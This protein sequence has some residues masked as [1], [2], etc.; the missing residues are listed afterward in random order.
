MSL[1]V[2]EFLTYIKEV[3]DENTSI[4]LKAQ[5][6]SQLIN[7]L[8][9]KFMV[10]TK[11]CGDPKV[12]LNIIKS[13]VQSDL[14]N[15]RKVELRM[16]DV[17]NYLTQG[18]RKHVVLGTYTVKNFHKEENGTY[19]DRYFI[20]DCNTGVLNKELNEKLRDFLQDAINNYEPDEDDDISPCPKCGCETVISKD[21]NWICEKCGEVII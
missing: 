3:Y 13:I 19:T 7:Y 14:P 11:G 1:N 8:V 15:N 20:F 6:D 12:A 18:E 16:T 5:N 9:G 2:T 21:D 17:K 10:K 4:F